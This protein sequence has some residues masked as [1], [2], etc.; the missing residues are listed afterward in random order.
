M[1]NILMNDSNILSNTITKRWWK[2][3]KYH[4]IPL[5]TTWPILY[6]ATTLDMLQVFYRISG[7]NTGELGDLLIVL[8]TSYEQL[9]N[10]VLS[11]ESTD[12][13]TI[14]PNYSWKSTCCCGL[15]PINIWL[16]NDFRNPSW[17]SLW[18]V[19]WLAS[20]NGVTHSTQNGRSAELR[21]L[22]PEYPPRHPGHS[23]AQTGSV[24]RVRAPILT[25][26]KHGCHQP[27]QATISSNISMI[28]V[29][30]LADKYRYGNMVLL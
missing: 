16:W 15:H 17:A 14:I 20:N 1:M 12:H 29:D 18:Q 5:I 7:P 8:P 30:E 28:M 19:A 9:A 10:R 21:P 11:V 4:E 2:R 25:W 26:E 13:Y 6:I 22:C 23:E 3:W 24:G 27:L